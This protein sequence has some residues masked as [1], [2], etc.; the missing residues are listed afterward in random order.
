MISAV[1][2]IVAAVFATLF[3]DDISLL[4]FSIIIGSLAGVYSSLV[5]SK[6]GTLSHVKK[7]VI[8]TII[9]N[10][11]IPG[12]LEVAPEGWIRPFVKFNYD[13]ELYPDLQHKKFEQVV[14]YDDIHS[15]NKAMEIMK[16]SYVPVLFKGLMNNSE[17]MGW[18]ILNRLDE[19]DIKLRVAKYDVGAPYDFLRGTPSQRN[20]ETVLA[21]V[22]MSE[23]SPYFSA[24]EPF[25]NAEE[26]KEI[27]GEM[28]DDMY[29]FD[30]NFLSNFNQTVVTSGTHAAAMITSWSL[31]MMGKKTWFLW[32]PEESRKMHKQWWGRTPLPA[33]GSEKSMFD[34]PTYKVVMEAGD[35]MAFPPYWMHAVTSHAGPNLMLNLRTPIG[36]VPF[37]GDWLCGLRVLVAMPMAIVTKMLPKLSIVKSTPL[38]LEGLRNVSKTD[39]NA[40]WYDT[41][42]KLRTG[43]PEQFL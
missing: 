5:H 16:E 12:I 32:S 17:E 7:A 13:T 1:F 26:V 29:S 31:Q 38:A 2:A 6:N 23:N 4:Y 11:T 9:A 25:L 20:G 35:V 24:F 36:W 14:I 21:G 33:Y 3:K 39:M 10:L 42:T 19:E 22:A 28:L 15:F 8:V 40:A 27:T 43:P 30:T 34:R 37:G 18:K 41:P